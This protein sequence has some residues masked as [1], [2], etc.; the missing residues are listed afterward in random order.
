ME[1]S[2]SE[3]IVI[4]QRERSFFNQLTGSISYGFG[5][6]S[7]NKQTNSSLA[8]DVA[9]RTTR[10]SVQLAT[11]SQFGSQTNAENSN[12]VTFDSEYA[13]MLTDKWLAAGLF[14]LLKSA[15]GERNHVSRILR[16]IRAHCLQYQ[17]PSRSHPA[18]APT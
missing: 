5:F 11:S 13:R 1:V 9:F 14:S 4:G 18:C 10:N 12:R 2:S 16:S 7:G 3:V 8:A 6:A 15:N 17:G